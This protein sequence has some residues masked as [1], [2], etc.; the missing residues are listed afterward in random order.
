MCKSHLNSPATNSK[1]LSTVNR[2]TSHIQRARECI[3]HC[4]WHDHVA[5]RVSCLFPCT[6]VIIRYSVHSYNF[7]ATGTSLAFSLTSRSHSVPA[8]L[9]P[10]TLLH[11]LT[12]L[13][14][15]YFFL[16]NA[17]T[18]IGLCFICLFTFSRCNHIKYAHIS[19]CN[20]CTRQICECVCVIYVAWN[21]R[22]HRQTETIANK[23]C[24]MFGAI[25]NFLLPIVSVTVCVCVFVLC[26]LLFF[27][28]A[29]VW[30]YTIRLKWYERQMRVTKFAASQHD[31]SFDVVHG[32]EHADESN[33]LI[34]KSKLLFLFLLVPLLFFTS[35]TRD[36]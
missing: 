11:S 28:D 31:Y 36:A 35:S 5:V 16:T 9:S 32:S 33:N 24:G 2:K 34:S 30:C 15:V 10:I 13:Q 3:M 12:V 25:A 8:A 18:L 23:V 22:A 7:S 27:A 29:G 1:W 17:F 4:Q 21:H 20:V 14:H 26:N 6:R 19:G